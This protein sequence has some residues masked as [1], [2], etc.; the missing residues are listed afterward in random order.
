VRDGHP[1]GGIL[2]IPHRRWSNRSPLYGI[3]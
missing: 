1:L 2:G 3:P